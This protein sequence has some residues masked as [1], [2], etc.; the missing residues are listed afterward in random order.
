MSP[1]LSY[2]ES[3]I[4]N[5]AKHS[6][7]SKNPFISKISKYQTSTDIDGID[8]GGPSQ[9]K[10]LQND[11]LYNNEHIGIELNETSIIENTF[12]GTPSQ[13]QSTLE[14]SPFK[15]MQMDDGLSDMEDNERGGGFRI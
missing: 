6:K 15:A 14:K 10:H 2:I 7:I 1:G 4:E 5:T 12:E 8:F 9:E 3:S 11:G 13:K